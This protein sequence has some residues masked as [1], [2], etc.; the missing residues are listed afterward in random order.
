MLLMVSVTGM[1]S[2]GVRS[3][4][5]LRSVSIRVN[6]FSLKAK[7]YQETVKAKTLKNKLSVAV[8]GTCRV[9]SLLEVLLQLD[10]VLRDDEL[11]GD[12]MPLELVCQLHHG[13]RRA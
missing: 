5:S 13:G 10:P 1:D 2:F 7:Q 12:E 8:D 11:R 6:F 4:R 3:P 9:S